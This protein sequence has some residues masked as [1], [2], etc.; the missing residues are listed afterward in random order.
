MAQQPPSTESPL[1]T[2][3]EVRVDPVNGYRAAHSLVNV[4]IDDPMHPFRA[5]QTQTQPDRMSIQISATEHIQLEPEALSLINHSCQPNAFFDTTRQQLLCLRTILIGDEITI[6][7]PA[8]EW[9]MAVG[10]D[11]NCGTTDCCGYI[12]G[13]I[14]L[15]PSQRQQQRL[16]PHILQLAAK[17][18]PTQFEARAYLEEYFLELNTEY[19]ALY[20]FWVAAAQ[21]IPPGA[22]ALE[23]GVGPTLYSSFPLATACA[24][25]D[26]ADYVPHIFSETQKWLRREQGSFDWKQHVQLV[27]QTE[28]VAP[29]AAN[30]A[31]REEQLR[32]R[33][34]DLLPCN[35]RQANPLSPLQRQ[36][37]VVTMHYCSE[38]AA[39]SRQ[40]WSEVVRNGAN[41]LKP[42][43]LFLLSV[44]TGLQRFRQYA[45]QQ[46]SR[47]P[48]L[49][50]E[51]IHHH[52]HTLDMDMETLER[53][54]LPAPP[55]YPYTAT[56]LVA[57]NK[58]RHNT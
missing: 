10:F 6:F 35:I 20:A 33:I 49:Q 57:V 22:Q 34:R 13:A 25:I 19:Q 30:I 4:A 51:D 39:E 1:S 42:G 29:S 28:G 17:Q 40:E 14:D 24:T 58:R 18:N 56:V 16:A 2:K 44:C 55:S 36:Y 46:L 43:G 41:L 48:D 31:G 27:L 3:L 23:L 38:A 37:D 32:Q 21:R 7:Y 52:L 12:G 9:Q 53:Q 5:A 50:P 47:A 54:T 11:C 45:D 15:S 8:T 26:L